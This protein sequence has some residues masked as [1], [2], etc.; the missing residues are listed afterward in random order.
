MLNWDEYMGFSNNEYNE[1]I[2]TYYTDIGFT[3]FP[4]LCFEENRK[5]SLDIRSQTLKD[6]IELYDS[7]YHEE[8]STPFLATGSQ[9]SRIGG[10]LFWLPK[11]EQSV[12]KRS[13]Y[14]ELCQQETAFFQAQLIKAA[15]QSYKEV[16]YLS[17]RVCNLMEHF[18]NNLKILDET[19]LTAWKAINLLFVLGPHRW[20]Q[21][22]PDG[23]WNFW[24][25]E[26]FK[27]IMSGHEDV[28][29][30]AHRNHRRITTCFQRFEDKNFPAFVQEPQSNQEDEV[31]N[32][33][34]SLKQAVTVS[35]DEDTFST[36][37]TLTVSVDEDT[38]STLSTLTTS[39]K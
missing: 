4:D 9:I 25:R 20:I 31:L 5:K 1:V 17:E 10:S 2:P 8:S 6:V 39:T 14:L 16:K 19:I 29:T 38:F 11:Y 36:L 28:L 15:Q 27:K 7:V 24:W 18:L 23:S 35:V 3:V 37:S 13:T 12:K 26:K 33:N 34:E 32:K 21:K 22:N 30:T